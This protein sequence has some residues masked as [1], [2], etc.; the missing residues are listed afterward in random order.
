MN[1]IPVAARGCARPALRILG[2]LALLALALPRTA[3]A[4][5]A[6]EAASPQAACEALRLADFAATAEAPASVMET[7]L[8]DAAG[9][10]PAACLV[11]GYVAPQVGFELKLPAAHW[12]GGLV[13]VGS[14][15]FAGSAEVPADRMVCD[16]AVRRGYACIHSDQGHTTGPIDKANASLDG[17]WAYGNLQAELDYAYRSLH[18]LL[19]AEKAI[20]ARYYGSQARHAYFIGCSNGGRQALV[21][22]QRFPWDF[23]GILA[24]EPAIDLSGAFTTFLYDLRALSDADGKPLFSPAELELMRSSAVAACDADDG[25][26]DGIIGNPPACRFDPAQLQCAAGQQSGCL[27]PAQVAAAQKVKAGART[28]QGR[29]LYRGHTM[30][31]AETGVFGFGVTRPV[32]ARAVAEFFR[33]LAFQPDAGPGWKPAD[34]DF[35]ADYQHEGVMEGLYASANPD[36]RAFQEAGGKLLLVQ[37]WLDSGTPFPLRTIDYYETLG[38]VAGGREQAMGFARLF[39]VPGRDHCGGGPGAGA[40]DYFGSLE[41]WVEQ[42]EAPAMIE[43]VHP[44]PVMPADF[45]SGR[46]DPARV[47]F[48]RPLYPW[49]AW[50]RYKGSGDP[51]D[52]RSFKPAASGQ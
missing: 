8:A 44:D 18:V 27:T 17:L 22:A 29:A 28:S 45:I 20:A 15:G 43:A 30:P 46:V 19:L 41:R 21:A 3:A 2:L 14:G 50:A 32:A 9:E 1:P 48:S 47:R 49:P 4:E 6:P 11:R 24:M 34:F 42:G 36:L 7:V 23:D 12:N 26:R 39:M 5:A 35:D 25:L 52:W 40:A 33:Y 13:E 38:R 37:G 10:V 51:N 16:D 31:G